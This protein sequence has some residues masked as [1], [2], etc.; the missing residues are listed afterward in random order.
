MIFFIIEKPRYTPY[1]VVVIE[2]TKDTLMAILEGQS[3]I[4][5][6]Q[7]NLNKATYSNKALSLGRFLLLLDPFSPSSLIFLWWVI[8]FGLKLIFTSRIPKF[9]LLWKTLN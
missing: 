2:Q 1:K 7:F 3:K 5:I 6:V 9:F 8:Y 4:K